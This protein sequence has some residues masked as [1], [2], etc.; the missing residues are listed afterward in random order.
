MPSSTSAS[1]ALVHVPASEL[2]HLRAAFTTT[3]ALNMPNCWICGAPDARSREHM[4]KASDLRS[5]FG[6][7]K[8]LYLHR[9]EIK[10]ELV[11]GIKSKKLTFEAP[12]CDE[13]NN[14]RTQP[15]DR[16][17]E[18][19][20]KR[21]LERKPPIKRGDI[22]RLSNVFPGEVRAAMLNVHLYFVKL[23][24]C[25]IADHN[26]PLNRN[27][28]ANALL[29]GQAHPKVQIAFYASSDKAKFLAAG[30]TPV[31][32]AQLNG[33][34]VFA[35]WLYELGPLMVNIMYS[36]PDQHRRGLTYAWHPFTVT[37]LLQITG[38]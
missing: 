6:R 35:T 9:G 15:Y 7:G 37:K 5:L 30:H 28:F 22:L 10:N 4:T 8:P 19:L 23:F 29:H 38:M 32:T 27:E 24:G 3:K 16:A 20:C 1:S 25:L 21:L 12:L 36:E 11:Q 2:A 33:H 14:N 17:W 13:C 31:Q 18:R 26:I 34:I